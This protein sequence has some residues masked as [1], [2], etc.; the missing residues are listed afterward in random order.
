VYLYLVWYILIISN[1]A[2]LSNLGQCQDSK[3]AKGF[4]SVKTSAEKI[5]QAEIHAV[6]QEG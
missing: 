3:A 2:T 1:A 5:E 4:G 6:C